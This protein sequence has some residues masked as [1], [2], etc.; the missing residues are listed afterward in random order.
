[1]SYKYLL[2]YIVIG[3]SGVGKSCL[4]LYFTD[5]RFQPIHDLT[6]GVEFGCKLIQVDED[7]QG[8]PYLYKLQ[9]WDTAGQEVFQSITRSYYR[10]SAVALIV[11][12]VT[13]RQSF[14]A[15]PQWFENLRKSANTKMQLV[16]VGNKI[17]LEHRRQ[18]S[19]EEGFQCAQKYGALFVET[20]VK[21]GQ[22]VDYAF[23]KPAHNIHQQL[24][25]GEL[26]LEDAGIKKGFDPK[27]VT[28]QEPKTNCC[29]RN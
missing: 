26:D 8:I 23:E 25:N 22:G 11:Y 7:D 12:D 3:N 13:N 18:V 4:L 16:L 17:D 19:F 9:I 1:M 21:Q 10:Q 6:I 14:Q 24:L 15:I 27:H 20:S 2:K 29:W 28:W 5:K